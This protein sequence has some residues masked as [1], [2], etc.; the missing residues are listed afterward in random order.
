MNSKFIV[1]FIFAFTLCACIPLSYQPKSGLYGYEETKINNSTYDL[2]YYG[3]EGEESSTQKFWH[4]RAAELCG[5]NKYLGKPDVMVREVCR[6]EIS[7]T[8][9]YR[10]CYNIPVYWG[11]VTCLK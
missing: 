4:K 9:P 2:N 10:A 3:A 7:G 8:T 11:R 6:N 1:H 5:K